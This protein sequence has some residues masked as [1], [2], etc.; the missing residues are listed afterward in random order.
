MK[1]F[2]VDLQHNAS[3][4]FVSLI[5]IDGKQGCVDCALSQ[6]SHVK[7]DVFLIHIFMIFTL[8]F[9]QHFSSMCM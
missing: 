6:S 8:H 2:H 9:L 4:L 1:N 7:E 3:F 5:E